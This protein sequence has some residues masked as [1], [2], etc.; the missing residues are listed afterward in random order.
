[1]ESFFSNQILFGEEFLNSIHL[2]IGGWFDV[3]MFIITKMGDEIFYTLFLP[4]LFWCYDRSNSVKIGVIFLVSIT[5]N[6]L[7]KDIFSNPRPD[8]SNLLE[9]IRELCTKHSPSSP[10]FPSGHTQ[11]S[12]SM[13]GAI[14]YLIRNRTVIILG[15]I[16]IIIIPYSRMYLGVHFLGDIVGGYV[17][18]F[19][20]LIIMIPLI[21]YTE[22]RYDRIGDIVLIIAIIVIP[23]IIYNVLPG[24]HIYNY[25]GVLSGFLLGALLGRNRIQ[26]NPRNKILSNIIKIAVGFVGLFLVK[27]GLKMILPSIPVAGFFRYWLMGFWITFIAP[28]I[29]SRVEMLSGEVAQSR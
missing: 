23:F 9:G 28:L 18:G 10:G 6:N 14:M 2:F 4:V 26:F 27:E 7:I 20:I 21:R 29:F 17:L 25:M 15:L 19:L 3:F 24:H 11:G 12:L 5:I 8:C 16:M 1:M 22:K 13:W